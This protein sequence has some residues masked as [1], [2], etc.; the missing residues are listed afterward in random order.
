MGRAAGI[1]DEKD[2]RHALTHSCGRMFATMLSG[3]GRA[4]KT[5]VHDFG[6]HDAQKRS[7]YAF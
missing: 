2:R 6:K 1:P 4:L 3:P 7:K 5:T